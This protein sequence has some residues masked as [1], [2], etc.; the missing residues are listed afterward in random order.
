MEKMT[1]EDWLHNLDCV[2]GLPDPTD[3]QRMI[4]SAPDDTE[5]ADELGRLI[6]LQAYL[7]RHF[8][9]QMN[10]AGV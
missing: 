3:L 7:F 2:S 6:A 4:E 10:I 9:Q 5:I 1:K 8:E